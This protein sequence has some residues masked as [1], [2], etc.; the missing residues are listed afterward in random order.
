LE[1]ITGGGFHH[2][3]RLMLLRLQFFTVLPNPRI[4][5]TAYR[6]VDFFP[7]IAG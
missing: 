5:Y 4:V 1:I 2:N 3:L 6:K 7:F